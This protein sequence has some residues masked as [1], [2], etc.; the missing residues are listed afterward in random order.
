MLDETQTAALIACARKAAESAYAP[1]S[2]YHV[3]AAVVGE[4]DRVFFG[5]NVENSSY[6][7]S[8]CAERSAIASAVANGARRIKAMV[9][10]TEASPP[11]T[12]CGACRQW[13]IELGGPETEVIC[14]NPA[15]EL[16]RFRAADLLPEAFRLTTPEK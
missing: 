3:G 13:I 8:L 1:Y 9:V 2:R 11:A 15:G 6:G 14:A 10:F 4:D 16:R 12:P 5:A 7:L